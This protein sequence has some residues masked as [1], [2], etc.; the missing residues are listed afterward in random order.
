MIG[1]FKLSDCCASCAGLLKGEDVLFSSVCDDTRKLAPGELFVALRGAQFDPH[2]FIE[3]AISRG[4]V[5]ALVEQPIPYDL[6]HCQV[7]DT[8]RAL[9]RL[10]AL[11]RDRFIGELVAITGSCG[12]STAKELTASILAEAAPTLA[13]QGNLNNEIGVPLTLLA[14]EAQHRYAVLEL[15]AS[16]SGEIAYTAAL[17]RPKVAVITNS[18]EAHLEGF[19]S[20]AGIVA[21]KGEILDGLPVDG[22]AVLN[23]DDAG[24]LAW[25]ERTAGRRIIS[26]SLN[27]ASGAEV[28][29]TEQRADSEGRY[30]FALNAPQGSVAVSLRL[31]GRHMV[32]NALAAASAALALGIDL[33]TIARGLSRVKPVGGRVMRLQGDSGAVVIDDSYNASPSAVKAAID[34]L[35]LQEGDRIL[36][37]GQMAEL[38]E[39]AI[40]LHRDIGRYA[41][42]HGVDQ[43]VAVGEMAAVAAESFGAGAVACG[44]SEAA[45]AWLQPRLQP[46]WVVLVKG[47]R[48]ARLERVVDAL[49]HKE[50]C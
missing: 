28:T 21:A 41:K 37:L 31:Y 39:A 19:G 16:H 22:V 47:S 7:A 6:P 26:F 20:H 8:R 18:G 2:Q 34:L 46:G 14:L 27:G 50:V 36:V 3:Q 43:L 29:A 24:Y 10:A 17:A 32:A 9:G 42:Q 25:C 44:N 11:N 4:A 35:C 15:G 48:S 33:P 45:I 5:A 49:S 1:T 23:R 30:R 12:K 40:E 38:G 13:T